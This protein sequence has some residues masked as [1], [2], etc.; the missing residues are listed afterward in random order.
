MQTELHRDKTKQKIISWLYP[1]LIL[2]HTRRNNCLKNKQAAIT[3]D[4]VSRGS[5]GF[6]SVLLLLRESFLSL[7]SFLISAGIQDVSFS[8]P[9]GFSAPWGFLCAFSSLYYFSGSFSPPLILENYDSH[10][11]VSKFVKFISA[12]AEGSFAF[13]LLNLIAGRKKLE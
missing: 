8:L 12:G 6:S 7:Y 5:L 2:T 13:Y 11:D 10:S 3:L 1:F 9:P 4:S